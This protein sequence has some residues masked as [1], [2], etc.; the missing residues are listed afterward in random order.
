[1]LPLVEPRRTLGKRP[2]S[3]TSS[4]LQQGRRDYEDASVPSSGRYA[5]LEAQSSFH[6][7][8]NGSSGM[9]D[10]FGRES[11]IRIVEKLESMKSALLGEDAA[12]SAFLSPHGIAPA[13]LVRGESVAMSEVTTAGGGEGTDGVEWLDDTQLSTLSNSELES[14]M[15]RYIMAVVKELVQL[16]AVDDDLKAE[17][18]SLD[19]NGYSLF[20]YCCLYNLTSL[21][22]V[23]IARGVEINQATAS[24]STALHLAVAAGHIAVAQ[25]LLESGV[26]AMKLDADGMTAYDISVTTGQEDIAR[27]LFPVRCPFPSPPSPKACPDGCCCACFC[28]SAAVRKHRH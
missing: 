27:L 11:K 7:T 24:G 15:E 14:L 4:S 12:P 9:N 28:V 21:I 17:M 3:I 23:L 16:A 18:D 6:S 8:G 1:M 22:P 13:T 2:H 26:D 10:D 25:L 20:H 5:S 19:A